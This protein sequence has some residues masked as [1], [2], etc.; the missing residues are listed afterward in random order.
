[1]K[2]VNI[3]GMIWSSNVEKDQGGI[4]VAGLDEQMPVPDR[5]NYSSAA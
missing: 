2:S 1:M 3:S 5:T 4:V